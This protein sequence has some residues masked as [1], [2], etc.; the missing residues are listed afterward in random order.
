MGKI[1][2]ITESELK[3]LIE[4]K[5]Q[6]SENKTFDQNRF[7]A[8]LNKFSDNAT[9]WSE[10]TQELIDLYDMLLDYHN[11][12]YGDEPSMLIPDK[13]TSRSKT[14]AEFN[15]KFKKLI[16]EIIAQTS[17]DVKDYVYNHY[18][19]WFENLN[20]EEN[21]NDES[22][23]FHIASLVRQGI[24]NGFDP[25]FE[26]KTEVFEEGIDLTE[27]E[28]DHMGDQ[29]EKGVLQ[30]ELVIATPMGDNVGGWWNLNLGKSLDEDVN[31]GL[32]NSLLAK[33]T[34]LI[35]QYEQLLRRWE[36]STGTNMGDIVNDI[37]AV[38][39]KYKELT[40]NDID[41]LFNDEESLNETD[42]NLNDKIY[43]DF[44]SLQK[45]DRGFGGSIMKRLRDKYSLS[46]EEI[47]KIINDKKKSLN[48][49]ST[50]S[51]FQIGNKFLFI[52]DMED[53]EIVDI[54]KDNKTGTYLYKLSNGNEYI[55][56][57]SL[58]ELIDMEEVK[59]LV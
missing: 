27:I 14:P 7:E 20:E 35:K 46:A 25:F 45:N 19:H 1:I 5:I 26:L 59:F 48:E 10:A 54:Q 9:S 55:N 21:N 6:L 58:Q 22:E 15:K 28:Y 38:A 11:D 16:R 50:T 37:G 31:G 47:S 18:S 53:A 12:I 2:K 39:N 29:I 36:M 57:P 30:G 44:L 32:K 23:L 43:S 49:N 34:D 3:R 4:S 24:T 13:N 52:D 17:D 40:G 56:E 42:N 41:D 33:E 8:F 51:K